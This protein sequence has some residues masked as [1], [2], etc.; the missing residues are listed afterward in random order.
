ME[1][2]ASRKRLK[3]LCA[4]YCGAL[5]VHDTTLCNCP[6]VRWHH[7]FAAAASA[8]CRLLLWPSRMTGVR[9]GTIEGRSVSGGGGGG[10]VVAWLESWREAQPSLE[11][12]T[13]PCAEASF[14]S[15]PMLLT[16]RLRDPV[17]MPSLAFDSL[18]SMSSLLHSD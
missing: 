1:D 5:G 9:V 16:L 2:T 18:K 14:H 15:P 10:D 6:P 13:H 3:Q 7:V 12:S 11:V 8:R 4:T 17:E